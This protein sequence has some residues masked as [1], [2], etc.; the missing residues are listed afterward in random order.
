MKQLMLTPAAG[1]RLIGKG[2]AVHPAIRNAL[3]NGSIA[4]IA[5]TTNAYVVEEIQAA[6]KLSGAFNRSHFFRG[7]TLPPNYSTTESGRLADESGFPGDVMIRNG[8][9]EQGRTIYEIAEEL[10]EGD[11]ILKGAN[12]L[13][14]LNWKAGILVGHQQGGTITTA[15]NAVIGRRVKLI[16]PV[17]LEKR[18]MVSLD[19]MAEKINA[20]GVKGVRLFPVPGEPFTEIEAIS[21]LTGVSAELYAA[22]GICGAE[23]SIWLG[24]EGT[25]EEEEAAE[26]LVKSIAKEPAYTM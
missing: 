23:G 10:K 2:M 15:L 19:D 25:K 11:V 14:V 12:A 17:G 21:L 8:V 13:D 16:L 9:L 20:P 7:I 18:V 5:G 22:G 26:A 6:A 1:K 24:V 4:V 3:K